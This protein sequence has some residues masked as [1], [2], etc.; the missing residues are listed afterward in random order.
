MCISSSPQLY[1]S[2]VLFGVSHPYSAV[3]LHKVSY[4]LTS[5]YNATVQT[6]RVLQDEYSLNVYQL[7][8]FM[9]AEFVCEICWTAVIWTV[10][11]SILS[12]YWRLFSA[13]R[14]S[15]RVIIWVLAALVTCWGIVVVR[16][17]PSV[18]GKENFALIF[19]DDLVTPSYLELYS[20]QYELGPHERRHLSSK[21]WL[22]LCG[23][24]DTS[25]HYR[26]SATRPSS[27]SYLE[28]SF[29]KV[30]ENCV[31]CHV[32]RWRLVCYYFLDGSLLIT[33]YP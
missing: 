31:D 20:Y 4:D 23:L 28:A 12:S 19:N 26:H 5:N 8:I 33:L 16:S 24:I 17:R 10:K 18:F 30:T 7:E 6:E 1:S 11:Y 21:F 32:C 14:R 3:K 2:S 15:T 25:Y 29:A 27:P 9:K 13:N 22:S